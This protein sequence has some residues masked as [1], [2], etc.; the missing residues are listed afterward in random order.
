MMYDIH[1]RTHVVFSFPGFPGASK[2]G[3]SMAQDVGV[4]SGDLT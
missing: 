4:P 2:C 1:Q 3:N